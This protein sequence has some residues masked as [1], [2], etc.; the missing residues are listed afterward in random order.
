[1]EGHDFRKKRPFAASAT[2][3]GGGGRSLGLAVFPS[4][5]A[6]PPAPPEPRLAPLGDPPEWSKLDRFQKTM[7]RGEFENLLRTVYTKTDSAWRPWIEIAGDHALIRTHAADPEK[8]FRLD[9]SSSPRSLPTFGWDWARASGLPPAPE[10]KPLSGLHIAIDPGHI[11][12]DFARMEERDLSYGGHDPIREGEMT[13][14][15]SQRLRPKLEALGARVTLVRERNEP[16]TELRPEDFSEMSESRLATEKFFYRTAEIRA[17]AELVN[18]IIR[19]DLVLCLHFN[20]SGSPVPRPGQDFHLLLNGAYHGS[21]LAHDDERFQMLTKILS[22]VYREE[23]PL[24][25]AFA[26]S[27]AAITRLPA[28][29]YPADNPYA[30]QID[31]DPFLW[32]RNLLANRLY[33]CPVFFFEPYTMNSPEFIERHRLGDYEGT[34][35]VNGE[36]R[37]SLF[38]E[39]A[40]AITAGLVLRFENR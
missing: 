6:G 23:L 34:K 28:Y 25:R 18:E 30:V 35:T 11:G 7:T 14:L 15:T 16:V 4:A 39:Y 40:Q 38:E 5:A 19:P 17:R 2:P 1:M 3:A 12:G 22:R 31:S 32:A 24:A 8:N 37:L 29:Q 10:G 21:E 20:A 27:F 26:T 13:L 36:E 9:F 33:E